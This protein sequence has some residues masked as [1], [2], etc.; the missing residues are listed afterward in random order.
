[1][2]AAVRR[3]KAFRVLESTEPA[4]A[5][6]F[7]GE[8]GALAAREVDTL[9]GAALMRS[10][11]SLHRFLALLM[12]VSVSLHIGVAWYYGFRWIFR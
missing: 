9:A 5:R 11:R 4:L 6:A 10:W 2:R 12:I 1:M 8:L 3:D 7:L